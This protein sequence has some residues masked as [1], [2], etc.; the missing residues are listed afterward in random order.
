M[1][2]LMA[3]AVTAQ[4]GGA[5]DALELL[6]A[7][8]LRKLSS[9]FALSDEA[10][11]GKAIRA[12]EPLKRIVTDAQKEV[13]TLELKIEEKKKTI[14]AYLQKRRDLRA[15]LAS[16]QSVSAH[17]NLVNAMNELGDRVNL[18]QESN[19][20]EEDL[21][22]ARAKAIGAAEKYVEHL[23]ET[24][25]LYDKLQDQYEQLAADQ[26]I[27]NAINAYT[28]EHQAVSTGAESQLRRFMAGS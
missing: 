9:H 28:D 6:E 12:A 26:K 11:I 4:D 10:Q 3:G 18:L 25:K 20:E 8:G 2:S 5:S 13:N 24:R 1:L 14:V 23:L 27:T 22:T 7:K 19:Q 16:A 17:N 15:Q 21:K